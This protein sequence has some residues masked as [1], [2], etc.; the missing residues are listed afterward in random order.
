MDKE[1]SFIPNIL[2]CGD[3]AEIISRLGNRL[4][5]IV[6]HVKFDGEINRQKFNFARDGKFLLEDK[7]CVSE[8]LLKM[9]RGGVD[10]I[11][12]Q[13]ANDILRLTQPLLELGCPNAK[14]VTAP[15]LKNL[16]NDNLYDMWADV[17]LMNLLKN[18]SIKTLLDVDAH[19]VKAL[20]FT[21]GA[22]DLTEIDC[23]CNEYFFPMKENLFHHVFKDF[24]ECSLR[25]Y[26]AALI[27]EKTP[28]DF[29]TAFILLENTADLV[30]TFARSGSELV[31]YIQNKK[32]NFLKVDI[33]PCSS[34]Q[35]MFCYR[36]TPTQD[37]VMYVVTH[38]PLP[39]E[40]TRTFPD[41]YEIIHAGRILSEDLSYL[42]DDMGDNISYLNPYINEVT[43]FYWVWKNISHTV[44]GFCHYRRFFQLSDKG[45]FL[46]EEEALNLLEH[47]DILIRPINR[48]GVS[49][50]EISTLSKSGLFARDI[51]RKNL[52]KTHPDYIDAFDYKM[53][54][55]PAYFNNSFV[56]RK[57]VFDSYCE[58]LFSFLLDSVKELLDKIN[59]GQIQD[60][61]KRRMG[62]FAE[63]MLFVWLMKNHLRVKEVRYVFKEP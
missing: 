14:L 59:H 50:G 60:H 54:F 3:E 21:K 49:F 47:Y 32:D 51:L 48:N 62:Y 25:H 30:I 22:N 6:G 37:F 36:K 15:E 18:L 27:S 23:I 9:I 2:L 31:K 39:A 13:Y 5:K 8:D 16:P 24:S 11:V 29:D 53:N 12:F 33:Y 35:W 63:A 7:I 38:K 34:G 52:M 46:T 57:N 44:V 56:M 28:A 55:T 43:A 41:K 1:T 26:N 45:T 19:F 40:H 20:I 4:F 58:W 61:F 10:Y 17:H 42:G